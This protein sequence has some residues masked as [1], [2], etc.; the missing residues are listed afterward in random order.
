M[1]HKHGIRL[2]CPLSRFTRP[3]TGEGAICP[4]EIIK[5]MFIC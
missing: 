1:T 4:P 5:D 2:Q 3:A